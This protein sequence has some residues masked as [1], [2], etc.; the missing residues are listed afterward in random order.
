MGMKDPSSA[1]YARSERREKRLTRR[2]GETAHGVRSWEE[3][4]NVRPGRG[5]AGDVEVLGGLVA[6]D[7]VILS[8]MLTYESADR[9]RIRQP[10]THPM[11]LQNPRFR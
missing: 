1:T 10:R 2:R 8:G 4:V 3:R 9:V 6:G 11:D 7:V 5:S